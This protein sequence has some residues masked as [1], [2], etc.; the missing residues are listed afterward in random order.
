M[1]IQYMYFEAQLRFLIDQYGLKD[2]AV[3]EGGVQI[4][5]TGDGAALTTSTRKA[6]QTCL[7]IKMVDRRCLD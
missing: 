7:G 5:I 3:D 6:S 1:A 2:I 4:A